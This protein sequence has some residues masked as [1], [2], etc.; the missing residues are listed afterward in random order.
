MRLASPTL[1][2]IN[3]VRDAMHLLFNNTAGSDTFEK[4]RISERFVLRR[5]HCVPVSQVRCLDGA[6]GIVACGRL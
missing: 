5:H 4:A 6:A 2:L 1:V 3:H